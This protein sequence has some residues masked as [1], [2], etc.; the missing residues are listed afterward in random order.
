VPVGQD[1][2][3]DEQRKQHAQHVA[4]RRELQRKREGTGRGGCVKAGKPNTTELSGLMDIR[5]R[6]CSAGLSEGMA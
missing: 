5:G 1:R 4:P 6:A 2:L 3:G